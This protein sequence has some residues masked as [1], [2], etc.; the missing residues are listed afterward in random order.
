MRILLAGASGF[1][2][3][4]LGGRLRD[5]GH[6]V[7][8]LVRR[9]A[10]S[11]DEIAWDPHGSRLDPAVVAD[12]DAVVNVAGAPIAHWPWTSGYKQTLLAS[13][14]NTTRTL[15]EAIAAADH[16]PALVNASAIGYFG[17]RGDELLD[18]DSPPGSDFLARLV[19][20]WEA[21]TMPAV[22]AG[23]R[24]ARMRSAIVLHRAGSILK[25]AKVPFWLGLGGKIASGRQWFPTVSLADYLSVASRLVADEACS[26]SYNVVAPEPATNAEFTR[27]LGRRPPAADRRAGARLRDPG[28]RRRR[29]GGAAARQHPGAAAPLA[30]GRLRVRAP[31]DRRSARRRL[32]LICHRGDPPLPADAVQHDRV[33]RRLVGGELDDCAGRRHGGG[34]PKPVEHRERR[35]PGAP[36]DEA[37]LQE[38]EPDPQTK[39]ARPIRRQHALI[40]PQ[41]AGAGDV[42]AQQGRWVADAPRVSAERVEPCEDVRPGSGGRMRGALWAVWLRGSGAAAAVGGGFLV[43][44]PA[45]TAATPTT[46]IGTRTMRLRARRRCRARRFVGNVTGQLWP[47]C[48]A[49]R[50]RRP[51]ALLR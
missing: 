49:A 47:S 12:H 24:V 29:P 43:T 15:A 11:P 4:T 13:R 27:E 5:D 7:R 42:D 9:R 28:D 40:A 20:Q 26:G 23:A 17:D 31:D 14:V 25:L 33:R 41:H 19:Q 46:A 30:A 35:L 10:T 44:R 32:R 48:G 1:L 37:Y 22:D 16:K 39:S 21:A 2:G 6:E 36:V 38:V 8:R 18:D 3:T 50:A 34:R 45:A 51:Q